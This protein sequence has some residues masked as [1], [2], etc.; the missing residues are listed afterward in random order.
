MQ[1]NNPFTTFQ[2]FGLSRWAMSAGSLLYGGKV[3]TAD[4][5]SAAVGSN[6]TIINLSV[7]LPLVSVETW[8]P[9]IGSVFGIK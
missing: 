9:G 1:I 3:N 7:N 8:P 5:G 6:P 2:Y 4:L